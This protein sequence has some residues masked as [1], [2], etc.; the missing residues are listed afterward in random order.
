MRLNFIITCMVLMFLIIILGVLIHFYAN[1]LGVYKTK[2][3]TIWVRSYSIAM[4]MGFGSVV[5]LLLLLI[6][7]MCVEKPITVETLK[8]I[9]YNIVEVT[10]GEI[11]YD[12]TKD[13]LFD[14]TLNLDQVILEEGL[15]YK[16]VKKVERETR[17]YSGFNIENV[18]ENYYLTVPKDIY[19]HLKY[20]TG[21]IYS[22]NN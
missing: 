15:E 6:V 10:N 21:T 1:P 13:G 12:G 2:K 18:V 11:I 9:D 22:E 20:V 17:N 8:T 3:R 14:R 16:L 5:S 19:E 4:L 7:I